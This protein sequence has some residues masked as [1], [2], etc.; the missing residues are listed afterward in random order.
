MNGLINRLE[1]ASGTRSL[2]VRGKILKRCRSG[3]ISS[4]GRISFDIKIVNDC[5]LKYHWGLCPCYLS[6]E[7]EAFFLDN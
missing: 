6:R 7:T 1:E 3:N 2:V 4:R 5:S